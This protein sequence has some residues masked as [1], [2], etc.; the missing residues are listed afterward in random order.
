MEVRWLKQTGSPEAIVVFGGWAVGPEVFDNLAGDQD[1]LFVSDYRDLSADLPDLS[2]YEQVSLLAWSFGVAAYG[3]WQHGRLDP[4]QRRIAV[5]GSLTPVD[6]E[7]GIPPV[8]MQKTIETLSAAS[9]LRFI[10]RV[11]G[12]GQPEAAIDIAARQEELR[13]VAARGAAPDPGFDHVWISEKD[14][15]FPAANLKRAWAGHSIS[16][17][18]APHMPFAEFSRW[19]EL[20]A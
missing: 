1:I 2:G 19:Q 10:T 8:V 18:A 5:N 17:L 15:I 9:Y 13:A 4:F 20:L 7:R 16:S 14:K 11:F 3:H 12:A 6:R